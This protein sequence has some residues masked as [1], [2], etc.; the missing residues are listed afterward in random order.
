M[1]ILIEDHRT[2]HTERINNNGNFIILKPE[3][4]VMARTAIQSNKKKEKVSQL[5]DTGRGS[6]HILCSTGYGSD[7]VKK[8]HKP[9]SP[10]LNFMAYDLYPLLPSPKPC[11]PIDTTD[12]RYLN[13]FHV[14]LTN[15]LKKALRIELYNNKCFNKPLPTSITDENKGRDS[16]GIVSVSC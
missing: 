9:D 11:E 1:K 15:S 6:Y 7:F 12:T 5:C 4:I 8:L 14:P 16:F 2:A 13:H 3:D 10:E